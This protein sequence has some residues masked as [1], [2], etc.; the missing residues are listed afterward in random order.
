LYAV[1]TE[2][3]TDIYARIHFGPKEFV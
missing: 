1:V 3:H 2:G